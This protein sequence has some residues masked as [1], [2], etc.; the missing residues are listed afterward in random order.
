M[1]LQQI[2]PARRMRVV[3]GRSP[4]M[5]K[6]I[7]KKKRICCGFLNSHFNPQNLGSC[8]TIAVLGVP[9]R[10]RSPARAPLSLPRQTTFLCSLHIHTVPPFH[11]RPSLSVEAQ[12]SAIAGTVT[13]VGQ[14]EAAVLGH[15][16]LMPPSRPCADLCHPAAPRILHAA[17][18][19]RPSIP[20][21]QSALRIPASPICTPSSSLL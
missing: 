7:A 1:Q 11:G 10:Q 14:G 18:D 3:E 2:L 5:D 9:P 13:A 21:N 20:E 4:P 12:R 16:I 15:N 19:A 17:N 6:S 8:T